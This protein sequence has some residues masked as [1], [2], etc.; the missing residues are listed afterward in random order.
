MSASINAQQVGTKKNITLRIS[1]YE[2]G[3]DYCAI[4][5]KDISSGKIYTFENIDDKTKGQNI[6]ETIQDN[7]YKNGESD[8]K[9]IGIILNATIEYRYTPILINTSP[10]EPKKI[11]G[12][13]KLKWM[14]N[15]VSKS[16]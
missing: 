4:E 14:I 6:F 12:K 9:L 13:K 7:Y 5:L 1:S 3:G 8:K 10:D 2:C 11:S 15:S 16:N